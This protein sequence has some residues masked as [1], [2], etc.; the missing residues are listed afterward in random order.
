MIQLELVRF[1]HLQRCL[2]GRT[3]EP[4]SLLPSRLYYFIPSSPQLFGF[5]KRSDI[6]F[7]DIEEVGWR[8]T[9]IT[10]FPTKS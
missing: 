7:R 5:S 4:A 1:A 10:L 2:V 3:I 8:L 9:N 6:V